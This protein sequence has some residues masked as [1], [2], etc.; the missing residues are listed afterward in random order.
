M[1]FKYIR[2]VSDEFVSGWNNTWQEVDRI[3]GDPIGE[4]AHRSLAG[5]GQFDAEGEFRCGMS[6][7]VGV[8]SIQSV[9]VGCRLRRSGGTWQGQEFKLSLYV[10]GT[11]YYNT[12]PGWNDN[13]WLKAPF[14]EPY[15]YPA[16]ESFPY[17]VNPD[18]LEPWT[19]ADVN[20]LIAAVEGRCDPENLQPL[21]CDSL[22]IGVAF[23]GG[24]AHIEPSRD[25][26]SRRVWAYRIPRRTLPQI[27]VPLEVGLDLDLL[28]PVLVSDIGGPH[29]SDPGWLG[30]PWQARPTTVREMEIRPNGEVG[31]KLGD[32]RPYLVLYFDAAWSLLNSSP[33]LAD[34]I[35]RINTGV[36]REFIRES[37]AWVQDPGSGLYCQLAEDEEQHGLG[38]DLYEGEAENGIQYSGFQDG[39]LTGWSKSGAGTNGSA[40]GA[41]PSD[42]YSMWDLASTGVTQSLKAVA[43]DPHTADLY[44]YSTAT[45]S[46]PANTKVM[47]SVWTRN[48]GGDSEKGYYALQRAFDSKYWRAS[49]DSW[50][51]G[52]QWNA[53]D[54]EGGADEVVRWN[55]G[56]ID[57]GD[58]A[59]TLILSV[60]LPDSVPDEQVTHFY[61]VQVAPGEA[62][63]T[64][65]LTT[66][67]ALTRVPS[68]LLISN[69]EDARCVNAA[70]GCLL[71]EVIPNWS[72]G[73]LDA[74]SRKTIFSLYIDS[75]NYIWAG[76][77]RDI[78]GGGWL[79]D[80]K[81]DGEGDS[82]FYPDDSV[83]AG[84]MKK[85]AF[86]WTG[87]DGE[88][89]LAPHST[90]VVVD[91]V[92]GADGLD[93]EMP[94]DD[95]SS[96]EIGSTDGALN[97]DGVI[98]M[99]TSVQYVPTEIET[100]RIP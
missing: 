5:V 8:S 53:I 31:L 29:G 4:L 57:V 37:A 10:G 52:I 59:T 49:D 86:R 54:H 1:A 68:Q 76:Y 28:D 13:V 35:M 33:L 77:A 22:Y 83:E 88:V 87:A 81:K 84:V 89:Y 17:T 63:S 72:T 25:T 26:G 36:T 58:D 62:W 32:D 69:N 30:R 70:R 73:S 61:G 19:L 90:S 44:A 67:A 64:P 79:F 20:G 47:V 14:G 40:I 39:D 100:T 11:H 74:S 82:A 65:I 3:P 6:Q 93:V 97:F 48:D 66:N 50:Q 15:W 80:V 46:Y 56:P 96:L 16:T 60:G 12:G 71:A 42:P 75:D 38:G 18:T 23:V 55:A 2:P 34:G 7:L 99:Q 92:K 21:H 41:D 27:V 45:P 43:G 9:M 85:I 94:E 91:G 95:E 51:S 24:P 98:R 78:D